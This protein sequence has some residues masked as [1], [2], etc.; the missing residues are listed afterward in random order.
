MSRK[1]QRIGSMFTA[2]ASLLYQ[3]FYP[4]LRR[5]RSDRLAASAAIAPPTKNNVPG[6]GTGCACTNSYRISEPRE[7]ERP[8]G[9]ASSVRP[10][11]LA[12]ALPLPVRSSVKRGGASEGLVS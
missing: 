12:D 6:S 1:E 9:L 3:P 2:C 8:A 7:K 5:L 10:M 4:L 11:K